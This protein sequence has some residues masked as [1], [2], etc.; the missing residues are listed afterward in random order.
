MLTCIIIEPAPP[1]LIVPDFS[2]AAIKNKPFQDYE[3]PD[4]DT[5]DAGFHFSEFFQSSLGMSANIATPAQQRPQPSRP[6]AFAGFTWGPPI[7]AFGRLEPVSQGT[8]ANPSKRTAHQIPAP[9]PFHPSIAA[10]RR[11][12]LAHQHRMSDPNGAGPTFSTPIRPS[13]NHHPTTIPRTGT[14]RRVRPVSDREALRQMLVHVGMSARKKVIE[15]G[16]KPRHMTTVAFAPLPALNAKPAKSP[17]LVVEETSGEKRQRKSPPIPLQLQGLNASTT[18]ESSAPPSPSPR[19][20]SAMSRRSVTPG[21]TSTFKS[22]TTLAVDYSGMK[23][24]RSQGWTGELTS[25]HA[26]HPPVTMSVEV[27]RGSGSRSPSPLLAAARQ[28]ASKDP[29]DLMADEKFDRIGLRLNAILNEIKDLE[30]EFAPL[31]R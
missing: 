21:L 15:S 1:D 13:L 31:R 22:M 4:D 26:L 30:E 8:A 5:S 12:V 17:L 14:G 9:S 16:K 2:Y 23:T 27:R 10:L 3:L 20:G 7:D 25:R 28:Q 18:S 29:G 11:P 19:P 24:V 6:S